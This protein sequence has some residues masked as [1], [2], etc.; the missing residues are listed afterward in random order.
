MP[1]P[2]ERF[3]DRH[4][5]PKPA[6]IEKMLATVGAASID[7]LIAET[8]PVSI[9]DTTLELP[10]ALSEPEAVARLRELA[11]KNTVLPSLIGLG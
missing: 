11:D 1:N 9:Y 6:D 2:S 10:A 3:A 5:G 7:D 4:I 8:V